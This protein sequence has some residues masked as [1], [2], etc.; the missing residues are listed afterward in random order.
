MRSLIYNEAMASGLYP[1]FRCYLVE[2]RKHLAQ[3][4]ADHTGNS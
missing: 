4:I 2:G 3:L 1:N